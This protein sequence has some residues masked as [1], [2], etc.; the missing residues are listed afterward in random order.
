MAGQQLLVR[1]VGGRWESSSGYKYS[2]HLVCVIIVSV[3]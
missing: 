1:V 2:K 3:A